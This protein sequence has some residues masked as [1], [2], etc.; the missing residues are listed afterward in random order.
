[1]KPISNYV[2]IGFLSLALAG[3]QASTAPE[4]KGLP[5]C[6]AEYVVSKIGKVK[7]LKR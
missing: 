1:M 6:D 5:Y 2:I 4:V 7:R 3:T